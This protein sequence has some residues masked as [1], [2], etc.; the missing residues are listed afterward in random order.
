MKVSLQRLSHSLRPSL[1][2]NGQVTY[3]AVCSFHFFHC[4][5]LPRLSFP[6]PP[7]FS[8]FALL[9]LLRP[10]SPFVSS[11]H[12][13]LSF[14]IQMYALSLFFVERVT[15]APSLSVTFHKGREILVVVSLF[16]SLLLAYRHLPFCRPV[17]VEPGVRRRSKIPRETV[18]IEATGLANGFITLGKVTREGRVVWNVVG[19]SIVTVLNE[20]SR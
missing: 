1:C 11:L 7:P 8:P 3:F 20:R 13:V 14:A 10:S 9:S 19:V 5:R 17:A 2:H 6:S 18:G 12:H 4:Q 15:L 16:P